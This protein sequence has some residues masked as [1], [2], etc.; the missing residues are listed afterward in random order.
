MLAHI[1]NREVIFT[2][3]RPSSYNRFDS[4]LVVHQILLR[5][6]QFKRNEQPVQHTL[7][8]SSYSDA[9]ASASLSRRRLS[10]S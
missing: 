9:L 1:P 3:V 5:G 7:T 10:M 8:L 4:F 2:L 6:H